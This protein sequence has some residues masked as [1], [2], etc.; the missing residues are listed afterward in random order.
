MEYGWCIAARRGLTSRHPIDVSAM[1]CV[2]LNADSAL[3]ITYGA[4]LIDSTPPA[5]NTSP[6]PASI[7]RAAMLIA[8]SPDAHSRFTVHPGTVSGSPASRAAMRATLRLSSPAWLA[9]P[10]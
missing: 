2:R 4:R 8:S 10:K 5:M 7:M 9:A 1:A 3:P 6:C